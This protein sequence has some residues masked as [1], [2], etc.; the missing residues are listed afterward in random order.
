[1]RHRRC[2]RTSWSKRW[3]CLNSRRH[4]L[5]LVSKRPQPCSKFTCSGQLA[6]NGKIAS[7]LSME[8]IFDPVLT[9]NKTSANME[10][11]DTSM[12]ITQTKAPK[13]PMVGVGVFRS[14]IPPNILRSRSHYRCPVG[15]LGSFRQA[16]AARRG[17]RQCLGSQAELGT[18]SKLYQCFYGVTNI[19]WISQVSKEQN[20]EFHE[21]DSWTLVGK[22]DVS[23]GK[24]VSGFN[25]TQAVADLR[26]IQL[27]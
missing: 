19:S 17:G 15:L 1:M 25:L 21:N 24:V 14:V 6:M 12:T 18:C 20:Y 4:A 16:S 3:K 27:N 22:I 11:I 10:H 2:G 5:L 7:V 9:M 13:K 8:H 23:S 26:Q